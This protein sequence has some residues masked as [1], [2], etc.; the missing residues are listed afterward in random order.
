M[1]EGQL[2]NGHTNGKDVMTW[3]G[4]SSYDG[5]WVNGSKVGYG[6]GQHN[7]DGDGI[8]ANGKMMSN[9]EMVPLNGV[10]VKYMLENGNIVR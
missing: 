4:G 7:Y 2:T 8:L 6:Y 9:L 5:A 3:V 10:T 1:Y